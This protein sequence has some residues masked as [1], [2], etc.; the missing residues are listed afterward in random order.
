MR[1]GLV[2]GFRRLSFPCPAHRLEE[3]G[4]VEYAMDNS[5]LITEREA[6][7]MLGLSVS[8]LRARRFKMLPP[9]YVKIGR[10]VRYDTAA[11]V[12]YI[13]SCRVRVVGYPGG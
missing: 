3:Q 6:A 4:I 7:E 10:A 8:T 1:S 12:A 11:L 13:E 5:R 2:Y 9:E